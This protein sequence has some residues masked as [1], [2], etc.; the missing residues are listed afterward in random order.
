MKTPLDL[1]HKQIDAD[2]IVAIRP[3]RDEDRARLESTTGSAKNWTTRITMRD[4][5]NH[6]VEDLTVSQVADALAKLGLKT[7]YI[8]KDDIAIIDRKDMPATYHPFGVNSD[9]PDSERIFH[10]EV[11][12]GAVKIW[13]RSTLA[14]LNQ[15]GT[16]KPVASLH[17]LAGD[18]ARPPAPT[19]APANGK[20]RPAPGL[21]TKG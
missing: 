13:L 3:N 2:Q 20:D 4:R 21:G 1:G 8:P 7:T 10:S 17:A 5:V 6:N 14:E 12:I 18:P 15:S 9:R 16:A 19:Q 11:R